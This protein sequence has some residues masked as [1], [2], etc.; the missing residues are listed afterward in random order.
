LPTNARHFPPLL[1]FLGGIVVIPIPRDACSLPQITVAGLKE[2]CNLR[3][4]ALH[5]SDLFLRGCGALLRGSLPFTLDASAP[6][7]PLP[8]CSFP[9]GLGPFY[10]F[11]QMV[12]ET[13]PASPDIVFPANPLLP[14]IRSDPPRRGLIHCGAKFSFS[15]LSR[16]TFK[17]ILCVIH[18]TKSFPAAAP[19]SL[20]S[21]CLLLPFVVLAL[22]LSTLP[23]F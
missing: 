1:F 12:F 18:G 20:V 21:K 9:W 10:M 22:W 4:G 2:P 15:P 14:I 19:P 5:P 16:G 3:S 6:R 17:C 13:V 23:V 8:H 11:A 7:H